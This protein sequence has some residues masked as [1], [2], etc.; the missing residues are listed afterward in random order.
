MW[1]SSAAFDEYENAVP[2][3][4]DVEEVIIRSRLQ[5]GALTA[6]D[7]ETYVYMDLLGSD[8]GTEWTRVWGSNIGMGTFSLDGLH[9]RFDRQDVIAV[10]LG[11]SPH[12]NPSFVGWSECVFHFGAVV[13][14]GNVAISAAG[15]LDAVSG[16]D[17]SLSA[18]AM[19]LTTSGRVDVQGG[20]S[21][22]VRSETISVGSVDALSASS[23]HVSVVSETVDVFS[24]D[25]M[26]FTSGSASVAA[27]ADLSMSS[28]A[29]LSVLGGTAEVETA[30]A[31]EVSSDE[32]V[33]RVGERLSG[34]SGDTVSLSTQNMDVDAGASMAGFAGESASLVTGR[35]YLEATESLSVQTRATHLTMTGDVVLQSAEDAR[36]SA[37][38]LVGRA[39]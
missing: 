31:L 3:I 30:S 35:A 28:G 32:V 6:G 12:N 39:A 18:D 15:M 19:T 27:S 16:E 26:S 8:G 7:G 5:G 9:V 23:A 21:T 33:V 25:L 13:D 29:L 34:Y 4:T 11:S 38:G 24:G 14:A 37:G 2:L 22:H 1:R 36:V 10:R 20:D 17:V